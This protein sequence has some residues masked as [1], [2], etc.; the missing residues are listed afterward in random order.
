[1]R[2]AVVLILLTSGCST[3]PIADL[4]DNFA[5]GRI[6]PA[7]A[8]PYGGVCQPQQLVP[9]MPPTPALPGPPP[10]TASVMPSI[11]PGPAPVPP[12]PQ[13]VPLPP[14]DFGPPPGNSG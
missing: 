11:V 9:P 2:R 5:P 8:A 7:K 10:P 6:E 14:P 3:A 4:L 1:M 12:V 13:P